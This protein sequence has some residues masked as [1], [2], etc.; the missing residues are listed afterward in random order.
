MARQIIYTVAVIL[1]VNNIVINAKAAPD[2]TGAIDSASEITEEGYFTVSP[3]NKEV[4]MTIK[5]MI[6]Y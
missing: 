4:G 5:K 1:V 6:N 2:R 3:N